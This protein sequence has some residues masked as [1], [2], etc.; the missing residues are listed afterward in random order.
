M[1]STVPFLLKT[2]PCTAVHRSN[3]IASMKFPRIFPR[4]RTLVPKQKQPSASSNHVRKTTPSPHVLGYTCRQDEY[5]R[6][7]ARRPSY[8]PGRDT[9]QHLD[10][11]RC[12]QQSTFLLKKIPRLRKWTRVGK[13]TRD[14]KRNRD[15]KEP[16]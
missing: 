15:R 4:Y 10:R 2:G 14:R 3:T 6:A 13:R 16:W 7:V 8:L 11:R 12:T 9:P 1:S 5:H